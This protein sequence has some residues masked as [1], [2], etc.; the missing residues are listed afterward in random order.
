MIIHSCEMFIEHLLE[1]S[2]VF[3]SLGHQSEQKTDMV[4]LHTYYRLRRML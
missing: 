4:L 2:T 1:A 3:K